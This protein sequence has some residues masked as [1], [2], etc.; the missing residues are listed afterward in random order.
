MQKLP[1]Q[2]RTLFNQFQ[3][4]GILE[5][6]EGPDTEVRRIMPVEAAEPGDLVFAD[7]KEFVEE[8]KKR[9]ASAVVTTKEFQASFAGTE[10]SVLVS[11]NVSLA[12][13]KLRQAYADR[14]VRDS[15]WGRLHRNA[16]IHE[17]VRVPESCVIAPGVVIGKNVKLGE[18]SVI[19]AN[20]V[21]E[22]DAV[23]GANTVIHPNVVVGYGCIIGD[24][25]ILKSGCI[26]GSD[27][28]GFAQDAKRKHHRIPQTGT[29]RIGDRCVIGAN[30]TIDRA[31]YGETIIKPG[32]IFDNLCHVAHN[33]VMGEDCIVVAMTGIAGSTKIGDR[34]IFSGQTGVLDHLNIASDAILL[35]RAGVTQDVEA[36]GVYAGGPPLQPLTDFL[37]NGAVFKKLVDLKKKVSALEKKLEQLEAAK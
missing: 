26:I 23:I 7:R 36:A 21:I 20:T 22:H 29:V 25:V 33:V 31:A 34:V 8:A 3:P 18:N 5:S 6:F 13:A 17:T 16:V 4:S 14:D 32:C 2:S 27:G 11:A 10:C 28:F 15:E 9:R 1:V 30:N 19:M 35:H 37:K 12:Q 24:E